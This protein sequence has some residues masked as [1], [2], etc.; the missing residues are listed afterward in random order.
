MNR[1]EALDLLLPYVTASGRPEMLNALAVVMASGPGMDALPPTR[2]A[3]AWTETARLA[4]QFA[5]TGMGNEWAT[6]PAHS[7]AMERLLHR[8][9][10]LLE[11]VAAMFEDS[12][13]LETHH[14][15]R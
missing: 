9:T 15:R 4:E 7:Q 14:D 10:V 8:L 5:K 12:L 3:G 1:E 6:P 2:L 13:S 11:V